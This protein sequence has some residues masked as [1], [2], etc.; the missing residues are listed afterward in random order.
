MNRKCRVYGRKQKRESKGK[1][2]GFCKGVYVGCSLPATSLCCITSLMKASRKFKSRI[3][4]GLKL[5]ALV[6]F[7]VKI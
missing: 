2:S 5:I 7:F 6:S 3:L 1:I 4:S